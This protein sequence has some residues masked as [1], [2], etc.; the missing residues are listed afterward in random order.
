M[1]S[2]FTTTFSHYYL[3]VGII[4]VQC[5]Y[6]NIINSCFMSNTVLRRVVIEKGVI[7]DSGRRQYNAPTGRTGF[8]ANNLLPPGGFNV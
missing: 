8:L 3:L 6:C 5:A 2:I 1:R 4:E 7:E